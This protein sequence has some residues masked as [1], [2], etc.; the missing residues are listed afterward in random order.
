MVT[1]DG[2][3]KSKLWKKLLGV[4]HAVL[5]DGDVE[6]ALDGPGAVVVRAA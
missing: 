4:E 5:E 1:G 3:R 2:V 6:E